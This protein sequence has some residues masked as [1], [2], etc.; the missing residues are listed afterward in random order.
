ML[1]SSKESEPGRRLRS[2]MQQTAIRPESHMP[3]GRIEQYQ[4]HWIAVLRDTST[5]LR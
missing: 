2:E 5:L 3:S 1:P 4:T